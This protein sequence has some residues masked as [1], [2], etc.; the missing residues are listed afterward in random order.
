MAVGRKHYSEVVAGTGTLESNRMVDYYFSTVEVTGSGAVEPVGVP[1]V[2]N[3]DEFEVYLAQDISAAAE[4]TLPTGAKVAVAVG[5]KAGLGD[6][7]EDITLSGTASKMTA[8]FRGEASLLESGIDFGAA[9]APNIAEFKLAL[10]KQGASFA[11]E[12][13]P[14]ATAYV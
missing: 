4:S 13:G 11:T 5:G 8:Y 2:W 1:L 9:T 6:N 12:C 14:V 10:E 7:V 3:G